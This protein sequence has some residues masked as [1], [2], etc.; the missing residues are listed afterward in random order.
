M[1]EGY[2]HAAFRAT[3]K[4]DTGP[5][6]APR[7]PDRARVTEVWMVSARQS[8]PDRVEQTQ[9]QPRPAAS[10]R[11]SARVT[12]RTERERSGSGG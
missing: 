4:M 1:A 3:G 11:R 10:T 6:L 8:D 12:A 7:R 9:Q 2:R 5:C